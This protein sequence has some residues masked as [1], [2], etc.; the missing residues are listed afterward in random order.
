MTFFDFFFEI[1]FF[2]SLILGVLLFI[3][4]CP[5]RKYGVLLLIISG[6]AAT[7]ASTLLWDF[8]KSVPVISAVG[9]LGIILCNV[10]YFAELSGICFACFKCSFTDLC[11]YVIAGWTTQHLS[12]MLSS[13]AAKLLNISV[14]YYDY[15]WKYFLITISSYLIVYGAVWLLFRK[16][17]KNKTHITSKRMLIPSVILFL[18]MVFL[19]IYMPYDLQLN[20]YIIMRLY[21]V[22]CCLIM[23]FLIFTA[24]MEGSL[25][26]EIAV[27]KELD[28]K[29]SA[30]YEISRASIDVIN[31]KCHDLKKLLSVLTDNKAN[32]SDREI[33]AISE[34]LRRYDAIVKTGNKAFDT[35]LTEKSL[36]ADKNGI[37]LTVLAETDSLKF[38]SDLDVY[39]LFGNVLDNAIEAT[40][41]LAE[42]KRLIGLNVR[43]VN[44]LLYIHAENC[45]EGNLEF[46]NGSLITTKKN[47]NEHG[48]GILSI[49]RIVQKYGGETT[50]YGEDGIFNIDLVIPLNGKN[51]KI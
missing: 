35:I 27:I 21:S 6:V 32:V 26:Y 10:F 47:T 8:V 31:T 30:Q 49:K 41:N 7:A 17:C 51:Q 46:K 34:E 28:R 40:I 2:S 39:S 1:Q 43:A 37:K 48:F 14:N 36:Y 9:Y 11:V 3:S 33:A 5:K 38:M 19:N 15:N 23:L 4:Y 24:F 29:K 13:I 22:A 45:Y 50:I 18:V 20:A 42:E 12:G 25:N 44:N 16:A